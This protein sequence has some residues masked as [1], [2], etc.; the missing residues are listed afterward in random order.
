MGYYSDAS[1]CLSKDGIEML[2][3]RLETA[4][5]ELKNEVESLLKYADCHYQDASSEAEFWCW[6]DIK[7]Y[8]DFKDVGFV[9]SFLQELDVNDYLFLRIG[10]ETDDTEQSGSFHDN[11][12]N[13]YL[14]RS[15]HFS[16]LEESINGNR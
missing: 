12:F 1:L 14:V 7:W 13:A 8:A 10:E 3:S 4:E 2:K 9:Q 16:G 15:I 6:N 5:P 11:P